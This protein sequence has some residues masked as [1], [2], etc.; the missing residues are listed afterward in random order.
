MFF[1]KIN[2]ER[3]LDWIG[4][5]D[6]F[7]T[8]IVIVAV[9]ATEFGFSTYLCTNGKQRKVVLNKYNVIGRSTLRPISQF[10]VRTELGI[11]CLKEGMLIMNRNALRTFIETNSHRSFTHANLEQILTAAEVSSLD[12]EPEGL[13]AA[14]LDYTSS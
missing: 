14:E 13:S 12:E 1:W 11:T 2:H 4:D 10:D 3:E 8:F 7:S 9:K 6:D 5:P